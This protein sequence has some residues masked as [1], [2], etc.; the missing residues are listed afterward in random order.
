[1]STSLAQHKIAVKEFAVEMYLR[2][3][4]RE[5]REDLDENLG[6]NY[7]VEDA[8]EGIID[9]FVLATL[10]GIKSV[11]IHKSAAVRRE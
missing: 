2:T 7:F 9:T 8:Y 3:M 6:P 5:I 10:M 1:M 4:K 11:T